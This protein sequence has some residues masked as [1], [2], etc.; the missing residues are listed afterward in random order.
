MSQVIL[1]G[2]VSNLHSET[3]SFLL[4]IGLAVGDTNEEKEKAEFTKIKVEVG[5][6]VL[7]L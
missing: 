4:Q 5:E 1:L 7:W 3:L 6:F 2:V